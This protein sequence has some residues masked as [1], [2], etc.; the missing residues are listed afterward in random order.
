[1]RTGDN[2]EGEAPGLTYAMQQSAL[3]TNKVSDVEDTQK[4]I[5]F[6]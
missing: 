4:K 5:A 2:P 3:H 6:F 1:M